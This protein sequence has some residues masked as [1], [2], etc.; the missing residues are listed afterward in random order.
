MTRRGVAPAVA[1]TVLLVGQVSGRQEPRSGSVSGRWTLTVEPS[2]AATASW[3]TSGILDLKD[4]NGALTGTLEWSGTPPLPMTGRRENLDVAIFG[5]W[6]PGMV[7]DGEKLD[8]RLELRGTIAADGSMAGEAANVARNGA[9]TMFR[10]S[11]RARRGVDATPSRPQIPAATDD[12]RRIPAGEGSSLES[13]LGDALARIVAEQRLIGAT[14][15]L[16][17]DGQVTTVAAGASDRERGVPMQPVDRM[18][19]GSVGKSFVAAT[20]IG[21]ALEGRLDLD[22]PVRRWLGDEP[23]FARVPNADALTLRWL[24]SHR[25]GVP[26]HVND[27]R[28]IDAAREA[29]SSG[30]AGTRLWAPSDAI[31]FV[32]DQPAPFRPGEGF[33]YSD[34]GYLLVGLVIERVSGRRYEDEVRDRFLKPL[35]LSSIDPSDRPVLRGLVAGYARPGNPFGLPSRVTTEAGALI[36]NPAIEWT[37]GGLIATSADLARWAETLFENPALRRIATTMT[38]APDTKSPYALGLSRR[39]TPSGRLWGHSGWF[40]GYRTEMAYAVEHGVGVAFQTN[41][42]EVDGGRAIDELLSALTRRK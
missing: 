27:R 36:V 28:F 3:P 7:R 41:T 17:I 38:A 13:R 15:A 34:T 35:A 37:G 31:A 9:A 42:D 22:D 4:E 40:P 11:W 39:E 23:W 30:T 10:R 32:L 33:L 24:L 1:L 8:S 29:V 19:A 26:N 16:S 21:L 20:T 18:L 14:A 25:G 2:L 5:P 6:R 12:R